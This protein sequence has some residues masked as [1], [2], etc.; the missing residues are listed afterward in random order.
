MLSVG[1][2]QLASSCHFLANFLLQLGVQKNSL[3]ALM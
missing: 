3:A 1:K 2:I